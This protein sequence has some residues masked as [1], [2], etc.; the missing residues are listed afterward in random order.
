MQTLQTISSDRQ[1]SRQLK[2]SWCDGTDFDVIK[3]MVCIARN[4]QPMEKN[5]E[6]SG[7]GD[8]CSFLAIFSAPFEHSSAPAFQITVR[9]KTSQQILSTLNQQRAELFVAGLADS[10]LLFNRAGLVA[11][12]CQPEICRYI[13]GVSEPTGVPYSKH[14]L[15]RCDRADPLI[16]RSRLVS[17]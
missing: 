16:W 14:I 3:R 4:P 11:T 8:D 13:S 12:W 1:R 6:F 7:N 2:T 17:G 9:A 10:E 15:Q 5:G